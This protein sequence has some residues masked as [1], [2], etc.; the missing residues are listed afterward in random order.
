MRDAE[1]ILGI[2]RERG[3]RGLPLTDAYRQ[4]FQPALYLRAYGRIYR[5]DGAM[6]PGTTEETADGMSLSKIDTIIDAVRHERYR[7]T[8]ARRTYIPKVNG[9]KRPLGI[10]T[11]SDK[12]LQE[13]IRSILEAY[14]EPQFSPLSHGFRPGRGCHTALKVIHRTWNGTTWFIEGDIAQCFDRLDH[15]VLL[16]I[17]REKIH[18]GRFLRFIENLLKA[19]YLED[20]KFNATLS[21]TPQGGVVSPILSNIYLDKL[22][23]F[24]ETVLLP[25]YNRG[26]ERKRN[27][28]YGRVVR[29]YQRRVE[30]GRT[31]EARQ[32]RRQMQQ[33]PSKDPRDP[34]FRRL[35]YVRYADDFLLGFSGPCDEAE[36]I[37]RRLSEFLRDTLKL[38]LS[39]AKTLVTHARTHAA[40]FL[41]YEVV[42][43]HDDHKHDRTGGRCINGVVGLKVPVEVVRAKCAP[44]L[45]NGKP[46]H[47]PEQL[48]DSPYSIVAEFQQEYRG[49]VEYYRLAYNLHRFSRLRWVMETALTKTLARKLRISVRKVY[50]RFQT[51]VQ[52]DR[53]PYKVLQ[54]KV[55][56]GDGRTPLVAQWGGITLAW[57]KNVV[58]D[59]QPPRVWNGRTELLERVLAEECELCGSRVKV[60]VHHVRRLKDL[61]R[62]G[63]AEP[64]AWVRKM[65]A[66]HRKTLVVCHRCHVDIHAGRLPGTLEAEQRHRRAGS[67]ER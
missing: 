54:V 13:V 63:R 28:A 64:P 40:R 1:T 35:R 5:N 58:L 56:R 29:C 10:P 32:L 66:R 39:E 53:G 17:L 55:E 59:D 33:L 61:R 57:D 8:P 11:W 38:E 15:G 25:A 45:H 20:W 4:L 47:R 31:E 67:I 52:T 43:L 2:I 16:A 60:E 49:I 27:P 62:K 3:K 65:A 18:D 34:M 6:T 26:K 30:A 44:Y 50:R 19:G 42:T 9:K 51:T 46:V 37:K 7:W 14:Y 22:D 36:E 21:G 23:K 48:N 41:G 24:V 12:L